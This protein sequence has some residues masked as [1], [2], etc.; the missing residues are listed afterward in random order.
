LRCCPQLKLI[1]GVAT[2][3][4]LAVKFQDVTQRPA[5]EAAFKVQRDGL[6]PRRG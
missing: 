5:I 2:F 1:P 3:P 4:E 6:A